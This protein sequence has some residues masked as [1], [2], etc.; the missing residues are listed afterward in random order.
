MISQAESISAWNTVLDW[1]S[2]VAALR[3]SRQGPASSSAAFRKMA[4]R[5]CQAI[6]DQVLWAASAASMAM[7]TSCGP[8][9]WYLARTC[10]WRWG[11]TQV[12]SLPVR[13]SLPPMISGISISWLR[14]SASFFFK[15]AR[16]GL[17]GAYC[18][19]GSLMGLGIR[20]LPLMATSLA[21]FVKTRARDC[22]GRPGPGQPTGLRLW[23]RPRML[24]PLKLAIC[25][26]LA[27]TM[28]TK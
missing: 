7:A 25:L 18:F 12:P 10:P 20:K 3:V 24:E 27:S 22:R 17:P 8:A 5:S 26:P 16:S 28:E 13:T 1:P 6:R 23:S 2:M 14:I 4:A 11:I 21:G 15:D 19:T 9:L